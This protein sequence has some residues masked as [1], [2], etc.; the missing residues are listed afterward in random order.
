[1]HLVLDD[2]TDNPTSFASHRAILASRSPYFHALLL[3]SFEDSKNQEFHLPP[4]FTPASTN[5]ILGW[6]YSGTLEFSE[7][8]FDLTTALEIWRGADYLSLNNLQLEVE[9]KIERMMNLKR[10]ARILHFALSPE[11]NCNNL[12]K[13]AAIVIKEH[14]GEIWNSPAIGTLEFHQ[15][16]SLVED[17]CVRVSAGSV[18]AIAKDSFSLRKKLELESRKWAIHVGAMLDAIDERIKECLGTCVAQVVIS[19]GFI[20]LIDGV[21]FSTDALAWLL[22]LIVAAATEENAGIIYQA[23]VGSVLLREEGILADVSFIFRN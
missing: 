6:I 20:D 10:A 8:T 11:V 15:Q 17:V 5:F 16:K 4:L 23:L 21:G 22:E 7:R 2:G 19:A 1:M 14:F 3:G 9:I 12:Q 13:A 18:T